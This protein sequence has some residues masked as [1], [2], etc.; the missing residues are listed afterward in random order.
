MRS[1]LTGFGDNRMRFP[2]TCRNWERNMDTE[3]R[4]HID[5]QI[6]EYVDQGLSR[7]EAERRAHREFGALELAKDECRDQRSVEWLNHIL[8]DIRHAGRSLAKSPGFVAAV[9]V[10]L[11]LG[12]GAATAI[13]SLIY[14]VLLKPLPYPQPERIFS[15]ATVLPRE[16]GS[17]NLPARIQDYL[18]WRKAD[19]AAES[20]AA[21]TPAQWNITGDGEPERLGG[22][23]VSANFFSFL[24]ATPQ[25]GREFAAEEET[26]GKQNVVVI[27]DSLWRRRYAADP[28]VV[29]K[30]IMLN[31]VPHV[32]VGIAPP[33]LLV[34]TNRLLHPA[35]A[36]A[37]KIDV[38]QPIAPTN[39]ELQGESWNYGILV[40]LRNGERAERARQQLQGMLNRSIR[41][42]VPDFNGE[43]IT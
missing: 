36:F 30:T 38:W 41:A 2:F 7:V 33:S 24:G 39:E 3:L 40:R 34:P 43:L 19:T 23:L 31:A 9:V 10:T 11:A 27:S 17:A 4:F 12:I 22:A 8:R 35:I 25:L 16:N 18:E 14:S 13:F 42:Q 15:V 29:G 26:P 6:Q 37:A 5:Q 1:Y 28:N 21:L 20:I 32:V